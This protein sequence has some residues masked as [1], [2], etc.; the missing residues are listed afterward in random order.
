MKISNRLKLFLLSTVLL[1]SSSSITGCKNSNDDIPNT[2]T[3]EQALENTADLTNIDEIIENLSLPRSNAYGSITLEEAIRNYELARSNKDLNLSNTYMGYIG[4]LLICSTI[5]DKLNIKEEDLISFDFNSTGCIIK[6][7]KIN[8]N[9]VSG[10]IKVSDRVEE[11]KKIQFSTGFTNKLADYAN[12]AYNHNANF[13]DLDYSYKNC[14][15]LLLSSES[16]KTV[17]NDKK[18]KLVIDDKKYERVIK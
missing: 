3:I 2:M 17:N 11:E 5:M 9:I 14:I 18:L 16:D 6:Y 1:I 12:M 7:N 8:T 4:K 13:G 15:K 10:N